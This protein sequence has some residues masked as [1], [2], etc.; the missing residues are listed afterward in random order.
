[1]P[2]PKLSACAARALLVVASLVLVAAPAGA[3]PRTD[4]QQPT[5]V[6]ADSLRYDD[7]KQTSIFVGNV[8]LTKGTLTLRADRLELHED[9]EGFQ[10]G[11]ATANSGK[12]VFVRQ[13]REG[14]DEFIEGIAERVEFDGR[15]DRIHFIS[16]A[17]VKRL[18]CEQVV[19]EVQGQQIT[20]DQRTETYSANGGPQSPTP[21]QRV[22]AVIQP[23]APGTA[24]A[25]SSGCGP[26]TAAPARKAP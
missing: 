5:L 7:L 4:N 2:L 21:N 19:D 18:L 14:T 16:K 8:A 15:N 20:Y 11:V 22:R 24:A 10:M 1:M 6:D 26:K 17:V 13:Q 3:A 23:R 25:P 9:P 12:L